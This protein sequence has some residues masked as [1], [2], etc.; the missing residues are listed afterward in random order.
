MKKIV[1]L[2]RCLLGLIWLGLQYQGATPQERGN[3]LGTERKYST[4]RVSI[5][6]FR[7]H[8]DVFQEIGRVPGLGAFARVG[9][10]DA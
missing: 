5:I 2:E 7:R 9:S 8:L 3:V 1:A 4:K 6:F 10:I